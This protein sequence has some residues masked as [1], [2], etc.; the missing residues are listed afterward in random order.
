MKGIYTEL[1]HTRGERKDRHLHRDDLIV[2]TGEGDPE[3]NGIYL[4]EQVPIAYQQ[5]H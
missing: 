1:A 4:H 5:G 3:E 2:H